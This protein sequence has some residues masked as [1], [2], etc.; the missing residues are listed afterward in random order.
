[1]AAS[2]DTAVAVAGWVG[3]A[4]VLAGRPR[5][6]AGTASERAPRMQGSEAGYGLV[7]RATGLE[8]GL[9]A[10]AEAKQQASNSLV[11]KK[12]RKTKE[13]NLIKKLINTL[14]R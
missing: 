2:G 9:L 13:G 12:K 6:R 11:K 1:M 5:R 8:R 7:A 14:K 3:D 4:G 10:T